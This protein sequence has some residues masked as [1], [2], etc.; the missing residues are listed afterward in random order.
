MLFR[1][2]LDG[3]LHI[4]DAHENRRTT[5]AAVGQ[6]SASFAFASN[7]REYPAVEAKDVVVGGCPIAMAVR[8]RGAQLFVEGKSPIRN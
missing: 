1:I 4:A 8:R 7:A 5:R 3:I 2:V 6:E